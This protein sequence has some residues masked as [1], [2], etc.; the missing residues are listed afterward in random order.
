[1]LRQ[2]VGMVRFFTKGHKLFSFF[3]I[4]DGDQVRR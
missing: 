1:M 2:V 3:S 4:G